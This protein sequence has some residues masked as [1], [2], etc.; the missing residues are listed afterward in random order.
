[1]LRG[2]GVASAKGRC[3]LVGHHTLLLDALQIFLEPE[4]E[5]LA[6]GAD[7][8]VLTTAATFRPNAGVI[9]LDAGEIGFAIGSRLAEAHPDVALTYLTSDPVR[10][11]AAVS[12]SSSASELLNVIR[13]GRRAADDPPGEEM[14]SPE[15]SRME[16]SLSTVLSTRQREVLSLLVQGLSMKEAARKLGLTARTIAFHKYAA[17]K[18]N[19]LRSNADLIS[20]AL[21]HG[22]LKSRRGLEN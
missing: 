16:A 3:M 6:V 7:S 20:F 1:M 2:V 5:V 8:D 21:S 18:S 9:D 10:Y 4:F 15:A 19:G 17:M 11:A 14:G 22:I 13:I 12:K